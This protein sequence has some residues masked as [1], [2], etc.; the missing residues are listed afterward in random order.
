VEAWVGPVAGNS[1]VMDEALAEPEADTQ[2]AAL[3]HRAT[4]TERR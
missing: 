2:V 1:V 3:Q 4:I